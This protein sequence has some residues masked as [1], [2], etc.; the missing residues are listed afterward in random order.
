[1]DIK[2]YL[3]EARERVDAALD[4]YLPADQ[5]GGRLPE[6]M[7]YSVFA[8]G[9]RLRPIL[10][11]AGAEAVG[12]SADSVMFCACALE[13][14]HTYSLVHD[15]LPAMDDDQLRRGMPTNHTVYGDGMA[16]LAG[17]G[18]LT[19]AMVLM[20][21]GSAYGELEPGRVLRAAH[22]VMRASG[23]EGMVLGQAFDLDAENQSPDLAA[24]QFIHSLKTGAI[25]TASVVSGAILAGGDEG[26]VDS[27]RRY[28]KRVGLAFQIADDLLDLEGDA[29][30]LGK[31]TGM[32]AVRGKMTYPGAVGVKQARETGWRLVNEAAALADGLGPQAEPL[33]VLAR[34]IMERTN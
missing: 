30:V 3:Q 2:S 31:A 17:D 10:C 6:A 28:G 15:D 18:L 20:S 19:Q 22:E 4:K 1:M 21:D 11:M 32:D 26:Q 27:L 14:V 5:A 9:K 25:I 7:R 13:M 34:Y 16:V 12:G 29:E 33:A 8:G 24:V 23:P